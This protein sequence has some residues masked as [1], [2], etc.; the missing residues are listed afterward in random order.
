MSFIIT[1]FLQLWLFL[2][3]TDALIYKSIS[4]LSP[5]QAAD[6]VKQQ[7]VYGYN[8][9]EKFALGYDR[10][11]PFYRN[12]SNYGNYSLLYTPIDALDTMYL[13]NLTN[14]TQS[15]VKLICNYRSQ[16]LFNIN[17]TVSMFNMVIQILGGL[18]SSYNLIQ[19]NCL[20]ELAI[21]LG[22]RLMPVFET[23]SPSGSNWLNV[24]L[25]TG[26][27]DKN[28]FIADLAGLA[29]QMVEFGALSYVTQDMKYYNTA[30]KVL[31]HFYDQ[32]SDIGFV[33]QKVMINASRSNIWYLN[34]T[35]IDAGIDSYYESQIKCWRL[36]NDND[37]YEMWKSGN[38]SI[39][40]YL[41]YYQTNS[42]NESLL[43]F[44]R[45]DMFNGNDYNESSYYDLFAA[46]F[47]AELVLS[48]QNEYELQFA[49]DN[50]N[51]NWY[52]WNKTGIEPAIYDFI[53][54]TDPLPDYSLNP[55]NFESNYYLYM[56]TNNSMYYDRALQY[57]NDLITYCKCD[58]TICDGYTG[59][60]NV[61]NMTKKN[62]C[63]E[64]FFAESMKYLYLTFMRNEPDNPLVFNDYIFTTECHP[65]PKKW[66][67]WIYSQLPENEKKKL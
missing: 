12:G 34:R 66:G 35:H 57:L 63:P 54:V 52:M 10:L 3:T 31:K 37:C 25:M 1:C 53:N 41:R 7:F 44:K 17:M 13:M 42:E 29:T 62:D 21:D 11:N 56:V 15:T 5:R 20:K 36:F 16:G 48:A 46:Y 67:D 26:Q 38:E 24:N 4:D 9:Y 55:E 49:I 60:I 47:A 50:Q 64:W 45:V 14:L 33:G 58:G 23:E 28:T 32:R 22:D 39:M 19:D 40:N 61:Q 59:I 2:C 6:L 18:L 51:A 65:M 30:K 43:W 8:A 27:V